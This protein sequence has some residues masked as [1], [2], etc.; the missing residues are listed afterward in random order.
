M[1]TAKTLVSV[2]MPSLNQA[3]FIEAAI[4]S[5]L[6]QDYPNL[7]LVVADG[8]STDGTLR[9]LEALL[10]EYGT[11]LRWVSEADT[12][13]ANAVNKALGMARGRLIGWLNSDDLYA[14]GAVSAAAQH[15][16][17]NAATLMVYGEG[18]HIDAAGQPLGRYPTRL[19]S[20][21]IEAFH[22]G[23]FICQP[24]VFL[25]REVFDELGSLDEG[26]STAFDFELWLRIFRRFPG[27]I[28]HIDRVQAF[29][30]LHEACITQRLRRLV[31]IEGI[32][33]LAQHLGNAKPHW[34][35]TYFEELYAHYPFDGDV[36]DLKA[37]VAEVLEQVQ[38]CLEDE[39]LQELHNTLFE[40]ARLN[41]A[42]PGV[43]ATLHPD[44]WAS[45]SLILRYRASH[46][47]YRSIKLDCVHAMPRFAP[48]RL[49]IKTSWGKD[50]RIVVEKPGPFS[51]AIDFPNPPA[52]N[53]LVI[54]IESKNYFVP[55]AL[56][57]NSTDSRELAFRVEGLQLID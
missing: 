25:R 5:V 2:L 3:A 9:R 20:V 35:L 8:G 52:G 55:Q 7:E 11:H 29:S 48:L 4:R 43:F 34:L 10:G 37:H 22:E 6:D 30:R 33:V 51:L 42:L 57:T 19:P 38:G 54:L 45:P 16:V 41:T 49:Q 18:E 44:G 53:N 24:T 12:G 23:C 47:A 28:A 36:L 32:R 13:P 1:T 40:D 39:A 26:L 17:D 15:F 31:A 14:P 46:Q 27:R 50:S 56:D 21:G